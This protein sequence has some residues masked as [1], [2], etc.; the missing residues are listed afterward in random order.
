MR[1]VVGIDT[2]CYT[3]SLALVTPEGVQV[4]R[5]ILLEVPS[6]KF[7]LQQSRAVFQHIKNLPRLLEETGIKHDLRKIE[8]V[9][10]STRPRPVKGSYMPVFTVS[11]AFGKFLAASLQIPLVKT[12]HQE[13]HLMAGI[14][15]SGFNYSHNF[16]AVHLS[17][18][19]SEV[20]KVSLDKSGAVFCV[21]I[22]GATQD[23]HAGQF[24]DRI[25]V[26]LGLPFPAG[27]ELERIA[28]ED[29]AEGLY[30]PS[31]V[32]KYTFSF[33]GPETHARRLYAKGVSK[34]AVAAVVQRCV[35]TTVEKVLRLAVKETR[36][37]DILLVGG[38]TANKYLRKRLRKRLEHPAVGAKLHFSEPGLSGDNAVGVALIGAVI[39]YLEPLAY[40]N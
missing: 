32:K 35:A 25:G 2:S 34:A 17:G 1:T 5:R 16:L 30:L 21:E 37:S 9:A 36:L 28:C 19:T 4:D 38:V 6:G 13:G 12:S 29:A 3:T 40:G 39:P 15:S 22:I 18:G 14:W 24:I 26:L 33:S 27:P 31:A 10:A 7:G 11:N 8:A 20:L 23:L